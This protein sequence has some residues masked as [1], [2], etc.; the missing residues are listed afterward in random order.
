MAEFSSSQFEVLAFPCNNFELLEPGSN[1]S[2]ILNALMWVRPGAGFK[3]NFQMFKKIDVNGKNEHPLF[4]FLKERCGPTDDV[5]SSASSLYY[6]PLRVSDVRWNYETFIIGRTGRPIYRY[7]HH[8][9]MTDI[10]ADIKKLINPNILS[11]EIP[12]EHEEYQLNQSPI[13]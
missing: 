4:T 12:V 7:S 9:N 2:E 1:Y 8:A 3:P 13:A 11:N 10:G 5:Y 6:D